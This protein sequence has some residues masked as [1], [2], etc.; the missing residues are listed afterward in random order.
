MQSIP[1]GTGTRLASLCCSR[2][3]GEK[4]NAETGRTILPLYL[5]HFR[6][7]LVQKCLS[8]W[9][10]TGASSVQFHIDNVVSLVTRRCR[11]MLRGLVGMTCQR[12]SRSAIRRRSH[13]G[14]GRFPRCLPLVVRRNKLFCR[15]LKPLLGE[16]T[17]CSGSFTTYTWGMFGDE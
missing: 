16:A 13:G 12:Q 15:N 6:R 4:A 3:F 1:R 11:R 9:D 2:E 8:E 14:D 17:I 5:V 10:L 7:A